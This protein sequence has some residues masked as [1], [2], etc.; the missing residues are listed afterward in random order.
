MG[1][2]RVVGFNGIAVIIWDGAYRKLMPFK[3]SGGA[4]L[5]GMRDKSELIACL[6]IYPVAPVSAKRYCN[7]LMIRL[8]RAEDTGSSLKEKSRISLSFL[9]FFRE[10]C[11]FSDSLRSAGSAM[12]C[13]HAGDLFINIGIDHANAVFA[14][15]GA[16]RIAVVVFLCQHIAYIGPF[17]C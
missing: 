11:L 17:C 12:Q 8:F 9:K 16:N 1:L 13:I 15:E 10:D 4:P 14:N 7:G 6:K 3:S 5:Q 2:I